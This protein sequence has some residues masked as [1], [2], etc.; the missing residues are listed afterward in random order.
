MIHEL[1]PA[2]GLYQAL[3]LNGYNPMD[4]STWLN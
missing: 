3:L 4:I 2:I 1:E